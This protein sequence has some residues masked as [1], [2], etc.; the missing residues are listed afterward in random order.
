MKRIR[1]IVSFVV[2]C[3]LTVSFS[4]SAVAYGVVGLNNFEKT[5]EYKNGFFADVSSTQWYYDNVSSVY[6]YGLMDGKGNGKFDP[7]GKISIAETITVA[8]R[9]SSIYNYRDGFYTDPNE[10]I[11][12]WYE[13]YT[14][15]AKDAGI[16]TSDYPNYNAPAT[17]AEFAKILAAS[18]DPVDLEEINVV[19]D[20]AIPDVAM[21]SDYAEAVYLLYRAGIL[22]GSDEL[23]SFKPAST[24]TRAEAAAIITRIVDPALRQSIELVGEY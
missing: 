15:Y 22:T 7:V 14:V 23:G 12:I 10:D 5:L 18:I 19:D 3:M 2:G 11:E 20:G 17:R 6:E 21:S 8:A 24:I 9:I 1:Q 13:P 16:I 4:V